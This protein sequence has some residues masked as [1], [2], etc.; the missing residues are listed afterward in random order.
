MYDRA[1]RAGI[2]VI[3]GTIIPFNT[4]TPDQN[5][6]MRRVNAWIREQAERDPSLGFVDARAAVA[7]PG[8]PDAL[9]SSPDQLHPSAEGYRMMADAIGPA[10][11]A[12]LKR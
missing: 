1:S 10:V 2:R 5:E 12:A 7:A 3:A 6:R 9:A 11:A 8:N 4:A